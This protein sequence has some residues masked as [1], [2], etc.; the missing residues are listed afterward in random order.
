M[1]TNRHP[2]RKNRLGKALRQDR[3]IPIWVIPK[4]NR[5]VRTHPG[6]RFWRR[7]RLKR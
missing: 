3:P 1:A 4:T 6:R 7:S 2:A 5:E